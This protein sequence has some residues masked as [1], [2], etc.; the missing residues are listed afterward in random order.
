M[1]ELLLKSNISIGYSDY[2]GRP[3]FIV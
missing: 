2:T 3:A 1:V